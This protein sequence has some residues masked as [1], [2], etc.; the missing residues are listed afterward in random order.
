MGLV[1][2]A[3]CPASALS[4]DLPLQRRRPDSVESWQRYRMDQPGPSSFALIRG[5]TAWFRLNSQSVSTFTPPALNRTVSV[6][7]CGGMSN[8]PIFPG[9]PACRRS[10]PISHVTYSLLCQLPVVL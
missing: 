9:L 2:I 10:L 6:E 3:G 1:E 8:W 7:T 5:S 4:R